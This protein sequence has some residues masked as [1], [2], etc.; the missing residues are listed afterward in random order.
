MEDNPAIPTAQLRETMFQ[1]KDIVIQN[2]DARAVLDE[3]GEVIFVYAFSDKNTIVIATNK[4]VLQEIF[5]RLTI[6]Y[7]TR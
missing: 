6:S 1:F 3:K 7:R 4:I 5:N 2:I